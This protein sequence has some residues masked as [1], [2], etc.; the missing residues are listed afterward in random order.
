MSQFNTLEET[1]RDLIGAVLLLGILIAVCAVVV[2]YTYLA[3]FQAEEFRQA[4]RH[5][6]SAW[7]KKLPI[8]A[9]AL[10]WIESP[11]YI[12][13]A[14]ITTVVALLFCVFLLVLVAKPIVLA[15]IHAFQ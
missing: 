10:K 15:F 8:G 7:Q 11:I 5:M 9:N 13:A 6:W 3:W 4:V 2:R 14:R 1:M 12:I